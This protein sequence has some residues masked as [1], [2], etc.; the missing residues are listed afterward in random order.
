LSYLELLDA[1]GFKERYNFVYVPH[2][3][4][5]L[6]MLV[7]V[8]YFF[9]NFTTHAVAVQAWD[10]LHGFKAW[11]LESNKVLRA[12]WAT[13]TQGLDACIHRYKDSPV[14]RQDVPFGCK[15]MRFENGQAIQLDHVVK[16]QPSQSA[17]ACLHSQKIDRSGNAHVHAKKVVG[18]SDSGDEADTA[19]VSTESPQDIFS[20]SI[21]STDTEDSEEMTICVPD[22]AASPDT[23]LCITGQMARLK[24]VLPTGR[25]RWADIYD[26][27][28]STCC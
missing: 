12:S 4:Q 14:L 2:D 25:P 16:M 3:F 20:T 7:N 8:G 17:D 11:R 1:S 21:C 22:G 10:K 13:K 23:V 28:P 26:D 6:P 19:S 15:P 24:D 9:V 5:R 27:E 18:G